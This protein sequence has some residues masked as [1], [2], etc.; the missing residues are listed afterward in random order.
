MRLL[1]ILADSVVDGPGLRTVVFFAGCPHHCPGCH[2]PDSWL[3]EGGA[4]YSVAEVVEQIHML[5]SRR[6]TISGGEPF[7][8]RSALVELIA[9]L[10]GYEIY[11]FTGY[12]IEQLLRQEQTQWILSRI[13]CLIDG[14]YVRSLHD[15]SLSIRGSTNQRIILKNELRAFLS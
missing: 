15:P 10:A 4:D 7:L 1:Q 9:A 6:I 8:Q 3:V 12:T 13:D 2:N 11:L 14:R 5:G